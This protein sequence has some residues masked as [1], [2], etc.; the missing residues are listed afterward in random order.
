MIR[1]TNILLRLAGYALLV[2]IVVM[3]FPS[4]A[5]SVREKISPAFYE[6]PLP[7]SLTL[8]GER[9]PLE[10]Q[11]VREMFDRE[12]TIMVW[13]RA[14]VFMWLK[15]AGRYFPHIEKEIFK[16]HMPEDLKYLAVAE[17]SLITYIRSSKGALGTWQFMAH[18][19]R[20]NG[21]RKDRTMDERRSFERST[22]A[23]IKYLKGLKDTF[24][25]WALALA[26]F[27]MGETRLKKEIKQQRVN[28]YYRLNLP[29]ETE[30]FLFRI[31]AIKVILEDPERYGYYLTPAQLYRPIEYDT[32]NV[33]I[34]GSIHITDV[35]QA[36]GIDFKAFKEFN[37]Q[38]LGYYLPTGRYRLKVPHG[39]GAEASLVLK[40]LDN[41]GPSPRQ[42]ISG[43]YYVVQP[44][45]TLIHISRR[46]G[47]PVAT[48]KRLN[49][50]SGSLIMVGQKLRIKP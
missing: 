42:D 8:C 14:Q 46:S 39:L 17:S 43:D 38:I 10:D 5:F 34:R 6:F 12:F 9:V 28:D 31:A 21:L 45:D 7:E 24:G 50:I 1:K 3:S 15:R 22:D 29:R 41:K 26:A 18:T 23:A 27:N 20:R 11:Y 16:A 13:D 25:T 19:G 37:P 36:I 4:S 32:V 49:G 44:G 33:S 48:I 30:R 35:A 2:N 47:V 40:R